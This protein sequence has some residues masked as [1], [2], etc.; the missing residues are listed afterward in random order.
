MSQSKR[1]KPRRGEVYEVEIH[2]LA[3]GGSGVGRLDVGEGGRGMTVFVPR[4]APGDRLQVRV[5]KVQRRHAEG[6]VVELVEPGPGRVEPSCPHY[7]EGCGGCSWQHLDYGAQLAAKEAEVRDSLERIGGFTDVPMQ[8]IIAAGEPWYYRNKMEF[9]FHAHDGLGLHMGGNWRRVIPITDCRLESEL[10]MR[11]VAFAR[12]FV[13]EHGL[14]SWDPET[15]EGFLHEIVIRHGR[16]TGETLV[17]LTTTSAA[18]PQGE[19]FGQGVQ[20]VDPSIVAVVRGLRGSEQRGAAIEKIET[21]AGRDSIVEEV[22]GLRF[23]LG[24]QTFFQT[25]TA[26]A[27]RMLRIVRRHV[28][29][30]AI[31]D[32]D[33][34]D[35]S[36]I[37]DVFCGVGFFSVALADLADEVVGVEIVEAS[38]VAANANARNNDVA[39]T[40]F[41]AGDA[42][43][44]IPDVIEIHGTPDVVVLDPPR[45]G[46]GGKVMRRIARAEPRRIIYVSCNPTTLARD[47]KELEPFG[48]RITEVQPID[49]FPQTY[50]VETVVALDR[51]PDAAV[52]RDPEAAVTETDAATTPSSEE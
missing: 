27:D 42:R 48:Y 3:Y 9:S 51:D 47:L 46:A 39:N 33:A 17:G 1:I 50:H 28:E 41:Y 43:R 49:L 23:N 25:N 5:D 22:A 29:E 7:T 13:A 34:G 12:E 2:G 21:L 37:L 32:R 20:A 4:S 6:S 36:L 14:V 52:D 19:A 31:G 11:I 35:P 40:F 15:G 8:P 16:G 26:Q 30:S 44:T 10:A 38:I 45:S 18:F 24:L